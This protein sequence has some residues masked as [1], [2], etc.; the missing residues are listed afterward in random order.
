MPNALTECLKRIPPLRWGVRALKRQWLWPARRR[1][2][3]EAY[4]AKHTVRKLH[5]GTGPDYLLDGWLASDLNAYGDKGVVYLDATQRF[6]FDDGCFDYVFTEHQIEHL[7]YAEG[8]F[9]LRECFRVLKPGGKLRVATPD[10][11]V[12]VG[13]F[14]ANLSE[15][16]QRYIR[17]H[18]DKYL[19]EV[20][21]YHPAFV[22]N[23]EA[24]NWGHR[25]LYDAPTLEAA[26]KK[27]GFGNLK[28]CANGASDDPNLKGLEFHGKVVKNE[29]MNAFETMVF[30]AQ[31][32]A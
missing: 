25:F 27:A 23:N 14:A 6:P 15:M 12:Y 29:E 5:L 9:M 18:M 4:F 19:P 16:Q 20:G 11:G 28:R 26:L 22:L 24:H 3:V 2:T 17:F 8:L 21:L 32:P 13:L 1:R 31:R 30:E 10:L 7:T